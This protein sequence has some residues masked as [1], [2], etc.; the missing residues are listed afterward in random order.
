VQKNCGEYAELLGR[1]CPAAVYEYVD[2][3][4][5]DEYAWEGK[6]LVINSQ[7]GISAVLKSFAYIS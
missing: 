2:A 7:V 5:T 1:A 6:K 3:H 4:E